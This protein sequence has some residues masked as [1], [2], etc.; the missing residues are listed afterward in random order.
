MWK[1]DWGTTESWVLSQQ[2]PHTLS[3]SLFP[4]PACGS[5]PVG[6]S[7]GDSTGAE[8]ASL[9]AVGEP[10]F[11]VAKEL[12]GAKIINHRSQEARASLR[13]GSLELKA[14][15]WLVVINF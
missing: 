10:A 5:G 12:P 14:S 15:T 7:P 13:L 6:A 9:L 1:G 8:P 4:G 2:L 3:R 11:N